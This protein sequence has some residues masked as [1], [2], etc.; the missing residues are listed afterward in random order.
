[1]K[2]TSENIFITYIVLLI[3][4]PL[5]YIKG[6]PIAS[7]HL[8]FLILLGFSVVRIHSNKLQPNI[9]I[10]FQFYLCVMAVF[11]CTYS[12]T[13]FK[14]GYESSLRDLVIIF[15]PIQYIALYV[16]VMV[17]FESATRENSS[18]L[19]SLVLKCIRI[20]LCLLPII[21][22][23][24]IF[25]LLNIF[26]MQE[27][28]AKF[29]GKT[30]VELWR[31]YFMYN[32]RASATLNLEPNSLG[33]YA[34]ISLLMLHIFREELKLTVWFSSVLYFSGLLSLVLSG[35]FTGFAIY[36]ACS[37]SYF[38]IYKKITPRSVAMILIVIIS[39]GMLFSDKIE[40]ALDR[41]KLG[42]DS[43]IPSSFKARI[44]NAWD[45]ALTDIEINP[46]VGI[47][48]SALELDYSTDNDFLDK[49]L[50]FGFIGGLGYLLFIVFLMC[51]PILLRSKTSDTDLR[52]LYFFSFLMAFAFCLASITGSAFKSNRLAEIFWIYYSLP[53]IVV[54]IKRVRNEA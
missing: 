9:P 16:L 52:K 18:T 7:Y 13:F 19:N 42:I 28:L 31:S 3:I 49:F 39:S 1:M 30:N 54:C 15:S 45:K 35:S 11:L 17:V 47:G 25:Q 14:T 34:A 21:A 44:N 10:Y 12:F 24:C 27:I 50:R 46:V 48:P 53:F 33:L 26:N 23:V 5:V 20:N 22:L 32:P 8:A 6:I 43:L 51:Y 37:I 4:G 41:Q 2:L 36:V 40:S 38:F 29:Y